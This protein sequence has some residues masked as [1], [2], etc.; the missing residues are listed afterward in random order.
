MKNDLRLCNN[1][2]GCTVNCNSTGSGTLDLSSV[3]EKQ[4]EQGSFILALD[5]NGNLY[6]FQDIKQQPQ[7]VSF[8]LF[9]DEGNQLDNGNYEFLVTARIA[10]KKPTELTSAKVELSYDGEIRDVSITAPEGVTVNTENQGHYTIT[11]L[12]GYGAVNISFKVELSSET[13]VAGRVI[14]EGDE[15]E[16]NNAAAVYLSPPNDIQAG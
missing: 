14:V 5:P 4:F 12:S 9:P 13:M 11:Q 2:I 10:N 15:N 8:D 6:K 1:L 7:D 3:P 16:S